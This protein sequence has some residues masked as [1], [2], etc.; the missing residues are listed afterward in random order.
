LSQTSRW[1]WCYQTDEEIR[2]QL[3]STADVSK[4]RQASQRGVNR[5][6]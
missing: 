6:I 3:V 1:E 5:S 2:I 4:V